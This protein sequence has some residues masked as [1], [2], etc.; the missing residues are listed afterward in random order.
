MNVDTLGTS[1]LTN[2][3]VMADVIYDQQLKIPDKF[4]QL[5]MRRNSL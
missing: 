4:F 3:S 1:L 5:H 2:N